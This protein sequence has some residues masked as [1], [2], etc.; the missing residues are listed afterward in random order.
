MPSGSGQGGG[1]GKRQ[2]M[3]ERLAFHTGR[4]VE[5]IM[6]DF[7]RDHW[8]TAEEAEAYGMIDTVL[9]TRSQFPLSQV[10]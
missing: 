4:P 5:R 6:T 2:L 1:A 9:E 7:D 10:L 3:A 8:F